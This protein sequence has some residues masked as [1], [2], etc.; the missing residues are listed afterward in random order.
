MK[1]LVLQRQVPD[2]VEELVIADD[3]K[4]LDEDE[5]MYI[6]NELD[7]HAL[8]QALLLKE[9][10]GGQVTVMSVGGTDARDALATAMAK[11]A[12]RAVLVAVEREGHADN[13]QLAAYLTGFVRE[14]DC[15]LILTGVQTVDELDGSLGGLLAHHLGMPYV[16]GLAAVELEAETTTV[17]KEYPGGLLAEMAVTS[18]AVLGIQSAEQPPRYVPISK[19]MQMKRTLEPQE[20]KESLPDVRGLAISGITMPEPAERAEML[21]DDEEEVADRIVGLLRERGVV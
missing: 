20:F 4:A 9:R 12:D 6:T 2:V 5:V 10:H 7:D 19:V 1:Y 11:G 17:R 18:P 13:H 14:Q 21:G 8:E 16:G 3:R 15:D